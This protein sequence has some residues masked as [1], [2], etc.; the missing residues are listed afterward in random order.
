MY[1]PRTVIPVKERTM[2]LFERSVFFLVYTNTRSDPF[3]LFAVVIL[4]FGL[5]IFR[6]VRIQTGQR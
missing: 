3:L 1:S 6:S 4:S 5:F 2:L